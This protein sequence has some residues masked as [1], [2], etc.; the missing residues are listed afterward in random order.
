MATI[1][2]TIDPIST[3]GDPAHVIKWEALVAASL[4]GNAVEM[5]GSSDRSV[6]VVGTWDSATFVLEGSNDGVNWATLTDPQGNAISKTANFLEMVSELT[7]YVR[8]R[9]SGGS[10][11]EDLDVF[12]LLKK[13]R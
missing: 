9:I 12:L 6:Q 5:P 11:S 8:P 1:A 2:H 4:V 13:V 7:R 3:W 10:G